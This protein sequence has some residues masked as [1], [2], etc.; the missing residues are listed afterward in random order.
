M[1]VDERFLELS[2]KERR[3]AQ[4]VLESNS[5]RNSVTQGLKDNAVCK[6][7]LR[8]Y[9]QRMEMAE[10]E[11]LDALRVSVAMDRMAGG[12]GFPAL[13]F[14]REALYGDAASVSL[15]D[16]FHNIA[17]VCANSA[18]QRCE[19]LAIA[20]LAQAEAGN[21]A[22]I[23]CLMEAQEALGACEDMLPDEK[24]RLAG[25]CAAAHA[26]AARY[27]KNEEGYRLAS[28]HYAAVLDGLAPLLEGG[29]PTASAAAVA[30]REVL[31]QV[32]WLSDPFLC[33]NQAQA[34]SEALVSY[35]SRTVDPANMEAVQCMEYAGA[36][37]SSYQI[38][39]ALDPKSKVLLDLA[40][41]IDRFV[42]LA[43]GRMVFD[44]RCRG[45]AGFAHM[46]LEKQGVGK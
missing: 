42:G 17:K 14:L 38:L 12:S 24:L 15:N 3:A 7:A 4:D 37:V 6:V 27:A 13:F 33:A 39:Y 40:I 46:A 32:M 20:A 22:S 1:E 34:A 9:R 28:A 44:A 10:Q 11:P 19:F 43:Q 31:D 21:P 23:Q 45:Y 2:A 41:L 5:L 18:A 30:L 29:G 36:C 35:F 25:Y 8:Q 16:H 26:I